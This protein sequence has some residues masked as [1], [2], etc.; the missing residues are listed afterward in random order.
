MAKLTWSP[1]SLS[2]LE[3]IYEYIKLDSEENASYFIKQLIT[4]TIDITE[5]P[6]SGRMVAE[7]KENRIREKIYKNYRI[8]YRI[9]T[10][11]VEVVTVLHQS[12]RLT[13]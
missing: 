7:F 5:F 8:I 3:L 11:E 10:D 9:S 2:D 4:S 12:R 13:K 6:F 1:R